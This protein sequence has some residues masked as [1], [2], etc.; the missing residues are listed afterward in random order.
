MCSRLANAGDTET[1]TAT[2]AAGATVLGWTG[3][4][5]AAGTSNTCDVAVKGQMATSVIFGYTLN[6]SS[7]GTGAGVVTSSPSGVSCPDNCS[8][9]FP[10]GGSVD[11][12]AIA[13]SASA[14]DGWS[15]ACSGSSMVC[16]VTVNGPRSVVATFSATQSLDQDGA[17]T[18]Y[19][20]GSK[21]DSRAVGG[22]YRTDHRA[23]AS[24][25]LPFQGDGTTLYTVTGPAMGKATVTVD[26]ADAGTLNGYAASMHFGVQRAFTG[27][28]PGSHTLTLTAAGTSSTKATGTRV[29]VDAM[30]WGG[31]LYKDP[32]PTAS[33]WSTV[34]DASA[35]G[36]SYVVNDV[37]GAS[38]TLQFTGTGATLV[39]MRGPSM[40]MARLVVDGSPAGTIDLY[41]PT[42][43]F[44]VQ[45]TVSGL[46]DGLHTLTVQVLGDHRAA[47]TG[48]AI[49]VDG[50]IIR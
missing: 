27:Y 43:T 10:A 23:G 1:L 7:A 30:R 4:C 15:G 14:F 19:S 31:R 25:S 2:P 50:W 32:H 22:S 40:G 35:S 11:L 47:S 8:Q 44:G 3:A 26:G 45:K 36:G 21:K 9:A 37:Q 49:T 39:T 33:T 20:W 34:S 17:G 38:A 48:S 42:L 24:I 28:G 6:V 5:A 41:A 46:S 18:G 13:D 29:A 16:T 12:T